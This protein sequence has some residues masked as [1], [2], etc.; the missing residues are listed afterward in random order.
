VKSQIG[1]LKLNFM[2]KW[3]FIPVLMS[4]SVLNAQTFQ[5]GIKAGVNVSNFTGGDFNNIEKSSLVGFHAGGFVRLPLAFLI[6][7]PELLFSSQG[8]KLEEAGMKSSYKL[9]YIN[10]PVMVQ[11][12]SDGGFYAEAGPQVGFKVSENV[13]NTTVGDFAKGTDLSIAVGLG[14]YSKIGV[15][16]GGRYTIGISKVGNFDAGN[17]D[18]DFRN[19]VF[20]FGI[21][22]SFFYKRNKRVKGSQPTMRFD[23]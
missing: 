3:M 4:A 16:I 8:A 18:P 1:S 6:I 20:Q 7:Q 15:G 22:Y 21:F 12:E 13:P 19:G 23:L 2:K 9:S 11:Y 14:Y 5:P 10:I 17:I